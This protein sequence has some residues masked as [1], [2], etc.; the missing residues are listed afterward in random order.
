MRRLVFSVFLAVLALSGAPAAMAQDQFTVSGIHV[1]A[2]A[3]SATEAAT[4]AI[5]SGRARA[6]ET[7]YHRLVRQQD[8]GKQP[9]L[10][11]LSLQ[12]LIRSYVPV[13]VL[14]S[15]TRYTADMTYVFNPDAVRRL[16][17]GA[18]IAYAD[19]QSHPILVIPMAPGYAPHS[20]WTNLFSN[21]KF[22]GGGVP[23]VLPIGDAI[24]ASALGVLNFSTA[25]W[26]DVEPTA[27]RLHVSEAYLALVSA[28]GGHVTVKLRRLGP[29]TSP[30]ISDV[31]INVAPG[32]PAAKAY[33]DAADQAATAIADAW[34][35]RAAINFNQHSKLT[36]DVRFN[37]MADWGAMLQKLGSVPVITD[38]GIEAMNLGEARVV[39]TYSGTP[40]QLRDMLGQAN[41]QLTQNQG[42]WSLSMAP[43]ATASP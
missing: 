6:W 35:A 19:T 10:D 15:T 40:E 8:W 16:F 13:N 39:L 14:R 24:D 20:A 38:V 17:R 9:P 25:S 33:A 42:G 36:V 41:F 34:K 21:P 4:I 26:A 2:S 23:L 5:N 7:L 31:L 1:D 3:A 28:G 27:S 37:S 12:R 18:N 22:S 30:P 29:G 43:P 11:D 32:V